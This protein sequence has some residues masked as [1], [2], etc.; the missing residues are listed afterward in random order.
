VFA[1]TLG[2]FRLTAT[3][4]FFTKATNLLHPV[5]CVATGGV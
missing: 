5:I 2:F 4:G 1:R 3:N